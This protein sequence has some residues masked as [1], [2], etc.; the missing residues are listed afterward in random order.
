MKNVAKEVN[1]KI[2]EIK[3]SRAVELGKMSEALDEAERRAELQRELI[4][5]SVDAGDAGSYM[6]A[7]KELRRIED[8]IEL[9]ETRRARLCATALISEKESDRT[10]DSIKV[11]EDELA[12]DFEK[13]IEAP[14]HTLSEILAEYLHSVSEAEGVLGTWVREIHANYRSDITTYGD[15]TNR[16]PVPVPVRY[17]VYEGCES[18]VRLRT[19]L[20]K[21]NLL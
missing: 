9:Y 3:S 1:E 13:E 12:K 10:I 7:K 20:E 11:Y 19:F 6:A 4:E 2:A 16:S 15:G 14:L 5:E 21:C 8:E 18:A 17:A